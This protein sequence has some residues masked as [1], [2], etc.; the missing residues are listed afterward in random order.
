MITVVVV[1]TENTE[2][3][4][5]QESPKITDETVVAD[6]TLSCSMIKTTQRR[7]K[8]GQQQSATHD[9]SSKSCPAQPP[10]SY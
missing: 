4:D 7:Q 9:G 2:T 1:V 6:A 8:N 5:G 3:N 10:Q